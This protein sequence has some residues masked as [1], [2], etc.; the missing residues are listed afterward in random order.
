VLIAAL[1]FAQQK[2]DFPGD[3]AGTLGPLHVKL[4]LIAA[5]DGTMTGTVD[6][7]DQGL[8][9]MPCTDVHVN[10]QALSS[11]VPM[12]RGTWMGFMG[13]NGASLSGMWNQGSPMALNFTRI[14]ATAPTTAN[15][16]APQTA[17]GDVKW[18]DYIFRF[19]RTGTMSQVF[20]G[21][22]RFDH[23]HEW[24]S[25]GDSFTGPQFGSTEEIIR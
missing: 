19:T 3:Y 8:T 9:G 4:H 13:G 16:T 24:R 5:S 2:S 21:S 7:P 14:A 20:E 23:D 10:G 25:A 17:S 15:T 18:D 1:S 11:S 12:V 6:S 22:S